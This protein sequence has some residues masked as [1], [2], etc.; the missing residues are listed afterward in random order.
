MLEVNSV[1]KKFGKK[2]VVHE[3]SFQLKKGIVGL[4]GPNGAGKTTFLRLL[5]TYYSLD[6]GDIKLGQLNW[7]KHTENV[8]KQIGYLPQHSGGYPN[9]TAYEYLEYIG[10]L[11]GMKVETLKE[12]IPVLLKEVNLETKANEKIKTFSG[13]MKQRLG[14]A[15][16]IL[17]N[18]QLL[19]V[20]EPTA[21]LDP[22]ERIRF[23][24]LIKKFG[25]DRLIILS[26]HITEDVVMTCNQI[27]LMKNGNI[28]YYSSIEE[29]IEL[30]VGQV[31][32]LT[33]DL[34]TYEEMRLHPGILVTQT[35]QINSS[36]VNFRFICCDSVCNE[37]Q[38]VRPTLEEGYMVWLNKK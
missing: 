28:E 25:K 24:N 11:R 4:L 19:L 8:R 18:P 5:S 14:I 7:N 10:I 13:G 35:T 29:V 1:T 9:L 30:A 34:H 16:A 21:G 23:R 6:F 20:D 33:T 31:W 12:K 37:A 36:I 26:T 32:S 27:L 17:H 22:E 2:T 38:Q 3:T 15:Q